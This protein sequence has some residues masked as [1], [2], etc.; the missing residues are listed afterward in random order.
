MGKKSKE[1]NTQ[2]N[3][4]SPRSPKKGGTE[5]LATRPNT[6]TKAITLLVF[7]CPRN[8]KVCRLK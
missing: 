8:N 6:Q 1:N 2:I 5:K 4:S 3:D 7:I